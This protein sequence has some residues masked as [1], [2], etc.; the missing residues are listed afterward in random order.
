MQTRMNILLVLVNFAA[1]LL[2]SSCRFG[3]FGS[4]KTIGEIELSTG[5]SYEFGLIYVTQTSDLTITLHNKRKGVASEIALDLSE[6]LP[7]NFKGGTYPGTGGTCD[8]SLDELESCDIVVTYTP[9]ASGA[10]MQSVQVTYFDGEERLALPIQFVGSAREQAELAFSEGAT[11][12]FGA[13]AV[14]TTVNRVLTVTNE[15]EVDATAVALTTPA[16]ASPFFYLGGTYPGTGGTCG[17]TLVAGDSCT[18]VIRYT[19]PAIASHSSSISL[20][21]ASGFQTRTTVLAITGSGVVASLTISHGPTLNFGSQFAGTTTEHTFT[22]ANSGG[23]DATLVA[24]GTPAL[25]A[26]FLFKNGAYPGTGGTCGATIAAGTSC[27]MV[28]TFSPVDD[29]AKNATIRLNYFDGQVTQ[30]ATRPMLG[31]GV[32]KAVLTISDGPTYNFGIVAINSSNDKT[33][34]VINSGTSTASAMAEGNPALGSPYGYKGGAFP[35][36]GGTCSTLLLSGES[37]TLVVT[38]QPTSAGATSETVR[39]SY[40]DGTGTTQTATRALLGSTASGAV[41]VYAETPLFTFGNTALGSTTEASLT[42]VNSG[43]GVAGSMGA[44]TPALS[45]PFSYKGGT[46]PG[47]GGTCGGSLGIGSSCL[48]VVNFSPTVGGTFSDTVR[49]SYENGST[50][51]VASLPLSGTAGLAL[52]TLSDGPTYNFGSVAVGGNASKSFTVTNSGPIIA[53]ALGEGTPALALP[54]RYLGGTYPGTDGTCGVSLA[55]LASCSIVTQ[56]A[57]SSTG[58]TSDTV[59]LAY[60]DGQSSQIATRL[61]TGTALTPAVLSVSDGPTFD[62]GTQLTSTTTSHT[63]TITNSGQATATEV[64][65]AADTLTAPFSYTSGTYP[66]TGG[67]CGTTLAGGATCTVNVDYSPTTVGTFNDSV[68]LSYDDGA[69]SQ[70]ADG[71]VTAISI[72]PATLLVSESPQYDFGAVFKSSVASKTFTVTNTG[73]VDATSVAEGSPTLVA[74]FAYAGGTF[75]GTGGTCDVTVE[76]DDSC[77]LVVEFSPTSVG[78]FTDTIRMT[79]DNGLGAQ[80]A[81]R[82]ILGTGALATL[83]IT[84]SPLF[85]FGDTVVGSTTTTTLTVTNTGDGAASV[86]GAQAPAL[87]LPYTYLGGGY[88]GTGGTCSNVLAAG[89]TC[90]LRVSYSP[91]ALGTTNDTLRLTYFD[92]EATQSLTLNLSGTGVTVLLTISDGPTYNFSSHFVSTTTDKIFTITNTGSGTASSLGE[93]TPA[94]SSAFHFKDGTFPGTGGDC[95]ATLGAAGTCTIVV[96]FIPTTGQVYSDTLTIGYSDGVSSFET[97]RALTGTGVA[98]AALSISD[99]ATYNFG[100]VYR[101]S[102]T[103]KSF[104][105]TNSGG[106]SATLVGAGSPSFIT[107]YTFKGG[108]FPGTGGTCAA[109]I[110]AGATCTVIVTFNPATAGTFS[111]AVAIAYNDGL[112]T[113]NATRPITGISVDPAVVTISDGPLYSFGSVNV[114]QFGDKSFT[115]T[116]SGAISATL[117]SPSAALIPPYAFRG[118]VGYPGSGGTCGAT[119]AAASS[120]VVIVRFTP[121]EAG[122]FNDTL[123][124]GYFDGIN[125]V[126]ATRNITGSS[127][128]RGALDLAFQA[129]LGNERSLFSLH[130]EGPRAAAG[131]ALAVQEDGRLVVAG[132]ADDGATVMRFD[133]NGVLDLDFAR[134]GIARLPFDRAYAVAVQ[135]DG[136]VVVAGYRSRTAAD[137]DFALARLTSRGEL[138]SEFGNAGVVTLALTPGDD[139]AHGLQL[140]SRGEIAVAGFAGG[141]FALVHLDDRGTQIN[142]FTFD[143]GADDRAYAMTVDSGGDFLL[144]GHSSGRAVWIRVSP[145]GQWRETVRL[146]STGTIYSLAATADGTIVAVGDAGL[147]A[148]ARGTQRTESSA[149]VSTELR[150]VRVLQNGKVAVAGSSG[151]GLLVGMLQADLS[152]DLDFGQ[153]GWSRWNDGVSAAYALA[154]DSAGRLVTAGQARTD[155]TSRF[156]VARF[157]P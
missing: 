89:Q 104:T 9:E 79:Y 55:A 8:D 112:T 130:S 69:G 101:N 84:G 56:Y 92:G 18:I 2:L 75:P 32:S 113:T 71:P 67:T 96:S 13:N 150:A 155:S 111:S 123:S 41:L 110:T 94:L 116:N 87:A 117:M 4:E 138:D 49:I 122:V 114:S 108:S 124:I 120:C 140:L 45:S 53:T 105:V 37:C 135:N 119:L 65:V 36:T 62:F 51:Q 39:L 35:G 136:R 103:D 118:G 15:G 73:D 147:V 34:T 139:R 70:I 102:S 7:F 115:L 134:A 17:T 38:F 33:F 131:R 144:G 142:A 129:G 133:E 86:L 100:T 10:H 21:Y 22:V 132:F 151:G 145:S 125:T 50:V 6:A 126:A 59:R 63:F 46:Y 60:N 109:T 52:L 106:T 153:R 64:A 99:G 3:I 11:Y 78:D 156:A 66:G 42:V 24:E 149:G 128:G 58:T 72:A 93:G 57:P 16:L 61:V 97:T 137:V 146:K 12:A 90:T 80:T 5:A 23:L 47:T 154:I 54:F 1:A 127:S 82:D 68:R 141:D 27:D 19:P 81:T 30:T 74:P 26:P 31:Q 14:S 43:G 143:L 98:A 44:S 148:Q 85:D 77:T 91:S 20:T 83:T 157:L 88:P 29:G 152:S 95:G 28:V 76:A 121:S 25:A 48:I 107:G 40:N